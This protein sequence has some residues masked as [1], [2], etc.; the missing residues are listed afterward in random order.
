VPGPVTTELASGVHTLL[1]SGAAALVTDAAEVV[2]LVGGI[3]TD[4]APTRHGPV[5]ARDLLAPDA[6]RVLESLPAT[7]GGAALDGV[8]RA[9][10]MPVEEV[11]PR[12][13]ELASLGFVERS[14]AYWRLAGRPA[15]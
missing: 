8:V 7:A 14:G 12:L 11:Q 5:L 4:L 6:Q 1:R 9:A 15:E 2:E 10:G 13:Y 3:G